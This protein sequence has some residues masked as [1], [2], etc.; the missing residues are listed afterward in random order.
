MFSFSLHFPFTDAPWYIRVTGVLQGSAIAQVTAA[1]EAAAQAAPER[2]IV[3]LSTAD[4]VEPDVMTR[5]GEL[6][7][8]GKVNL[9]L[10][11]G[12]LVPAASPKLAAV[13]GESQVEARE[14]LLGYIRQRREQGLEDSDAIREMLVQLSPV[15]AA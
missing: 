5:L 10:Q 12:R 7:E 8:R 3:D 2:P 13:L 11:L 9:I 1:I 14:A 6:V 4:R 15:H